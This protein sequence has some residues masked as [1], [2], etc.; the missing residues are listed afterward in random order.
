MKIDTKNQIITVDLT[1]DKRTIL[2]K[3]AEIA[4][5]VCKTKDITF[6]DFE[7]AFYAGQLAMSM[8]ILMAKINSLKGDKG[9]E[10]FLKS[11]EEDD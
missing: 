8:T 2:C 3:I 5:I 4:V 1:K 10:E 7:K 6:E 11:L 9:A